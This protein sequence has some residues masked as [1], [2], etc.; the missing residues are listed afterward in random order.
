MRTTSDHAAAIVVLHDARPLRGRRIRQ[1]H[2]G[3]SNGR[4]HDLTVLEGGALSRYRPRT[5][6]G[7][8]TIRVLLAESVG[9]IRAGLRSI[10]ESEHDITV[11]A[12]ALS[13]EEVVAL[14][15]DT[16]P[17]VILIDVGIAGLG[18]IDAAREIREDPNLSK[19]SV[20]MLTADEHEEDVYGAVRSGASGFLLLDTE[21]V[22]LVRAVRVVARGGAQL[23]PWATRCLLEELASRPDPQRA[24]P[25][26]F[27]ELTAR[28]RQIAS[29]VALGLTNSEIARQLVVSPATVKTHVSRAMVKLHV[30]DR[31]KL[32]ALAYQT[33]FV[34]DRRAA[35]AALAREGPAPPLAAG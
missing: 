17:D 7:S 29:L 27:D 33:G 24:S 2:G 30:R 19:V 22:E 21:P 8:P 18:A 16:R 26:I 5:P 6:K 35:D 32:V 31:A 1:A 11:A 4:S 20:V 28:E 9:L 15:T 10:L 14:A 12:E 25:E 13:G 34:H 3:S 23:S